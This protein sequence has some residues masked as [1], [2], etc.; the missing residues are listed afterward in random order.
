MTNFISLNKEKLYVSAVNEADDDRKKDNFSGEEQDL[1]EKKAKSLDGK[2]E[3]SVIEKK[4]MQAL[5]LISDLK[6]S[7]NEGHSIDSFL[8]EARA[9]NMDAGLV[10]QILG[11]VKKDPHKFAPEEII[12]LISKKQVPSGKFRAG[13]FSLKKDDT[14]LT[15]LCTF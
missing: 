15:R 4:I 1:D 6:K 14:L 7:L 5:S 10:L 11:L 12:R 2:I 13:R 3:R 8:D 9:K